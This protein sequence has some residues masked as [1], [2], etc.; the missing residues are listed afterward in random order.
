MDLTKAGRQH[1][2]KKLA[3][4]E[5]MKDEFVQEGNE[6]LYTHRFDEAYRYAN[7]P[8]GWDNRYLYVV[9]V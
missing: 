7:W 9:Q 5:T 6:A 4:L 3:V 2:L 1:W 8:V